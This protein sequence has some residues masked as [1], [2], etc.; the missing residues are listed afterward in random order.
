L[1]TPLAETYEISFEE[2]G[3]KEAGYSNMGLH[4][5]IPAL[6]FAG[7]N[8]HQAWVEGAAKNR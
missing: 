1:A 5:M 7:G 4:L 2:M 8:D 6:A 3:P